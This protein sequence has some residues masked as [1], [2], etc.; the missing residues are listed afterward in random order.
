[1]QHFLRSTCYADVTQRYLYQTA[2]GDK[3]IKKY[4]CIFCPVPCGLG[5]FF[6]CAYEK[7][8]QVFLQDNSKFLA[9]FL[10][11]AV[12]YRFFLAC[13]MMSAMR[14]SESA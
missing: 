2:S 7:K 1:M 11:Y 10:E 13:L 3:E 8:M 5:E 6:L 12:S 9:I 14:S 4:T